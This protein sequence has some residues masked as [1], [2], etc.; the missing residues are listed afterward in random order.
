MKEKES[1]LK[2]GINLFQRKESE[3]LENKCILLLNKSK[4]NQKELKILQEIHMN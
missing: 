3:L 4:E 2:K 1:T